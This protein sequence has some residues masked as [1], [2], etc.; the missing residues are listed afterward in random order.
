MVLSLWPY[1]HGST[2]MALQWGL[3][4][5]GSTLMN[6]PLWFCHRGS[7]HSIL[8]IP[9]RFPIALGTIQQMVPGAPG[10]RW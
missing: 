4:H 2:I 7:I 1:H 10:K 3:H 9:Q 5:Y 8:A 6:L